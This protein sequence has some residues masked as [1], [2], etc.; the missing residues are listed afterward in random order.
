LSNEYKQIDIS[1]FDYIIPSIDYLPTVEQ[2]RKYKSYSNNLLDKDSSKEHVLIKCTN[3]NELKS[4]LVELGDFYNQARS[5]HIDFVEQIISTYLHGDKYQL[6]QKLDLSAEILARIERIDLKQIDR[7]IEITYNTDNSLKQLKNDANILLN[8][9][10]EGNSLSGVS[11]ALKKPFLSKEIK[12]R[13]YIIESIKVNG[14]LCDTKEELMLVIQDIELKQD[15]NEFSQLW[16]LAPVKDCSYSE[17]LY[18]NN[19]HSEVTKLVKIIEDSEMLRFS[20]ENLSGL[21]IKPFDCKNVNDLIK[22][23][24]Y[25]HL[26][27]NV[28]VFNETISK[29][30]AY[31]SQDNIHP[32]SET[33]LIN[34]EQSDYISY[35]Q[36][37]ITIEEL[38]KRKADFMNFID[39]KKQLQNNLPNLVDSILSGQFKMSD[40][41]QFQQGVYFRHAQNEIHKLM[42]INY[43]HTLFNEI[44]ELESKEKKVIAKIA[45]KK[46]WS[47]VLQG[48]YQNRALRQ[49]L[50]AWVQAVK[51]IGKTGQGKR[52]LKFRKEA[53][54]QMDKCKSSVPCWIMPL[55]KVAE[56]IQPE[57]GMYDYI[58]IDEAS[59]LGPDAIFLLYISKNII[60][61]G[62]DKQTSPEYVGVDVNTMTPY[63][64]KHL[65]DIPFAN[66]Y[67]T[68]FS[69]FDHARRFCD[70]IT[71]LREHFRCMPEIIEFSNKHFY[72]PDGKGLYPLKQYSEN[73]LE[74]LQTVF[75]QDGYTDGKGA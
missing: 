30:R 74:P 31:L 19:I 32:I 67:G 40:L 8:Y 50:E 15:F 26:L 58:I 64:N 16:S 73:R 47:H 3:Y 54:Q 36:T 20:I 13:L 72:A 52:A 62:D 61:V 6:K 25:N 38:A 66:Y 34:I 33:I 11:F 27:K 57:Q 43:E 60:I 2:I 65:K 23:T 5:L 55:Y 22:E 71:V 44:K 10:N 4:K 18:F 70:G 35:E 75:C 24:E 9:L 53:Q 41:P 46:A 21:Q 51:K 42:D 7:D 49:H 37:L 39:L 45:S 48:L 29:A 14:S 17:F 12:E 69:F 59:Q 68:E 28:E 56:T 63:I 1:E